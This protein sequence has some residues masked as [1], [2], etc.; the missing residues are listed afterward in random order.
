MRIK[1]LISNYVII[2]FGCFSWQIA[3]QISIINWMLILNY[4]LQIFVCGKY[5]VPYFFRLTEDTEVNLKL[6]K[7]KDQQ[8]QT[9]LVNSLYQR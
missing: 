3:R 1:K 9:V 6:D 4:E 8:L 5:F 2:C 7:I